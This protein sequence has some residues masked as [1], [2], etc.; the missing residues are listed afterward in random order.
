MK[1]AF[2]TFTL[3]MFL[4]NSFAV[5]AWAKPCFEE[6]KPMPTM[7]HEMGDIP[8][9]EK[10]DVPKKSGQHCEGACLCLHTSM[11][12]MN[13]PG[14]SVISDIEMREAKPAINNNEDAASVKTAPPRRPPKLYS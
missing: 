5:A 12:Q 7:S 8:C 11:T 14:D 10:Q 3:I 13:I 2:L 9:H 1:A 4:A 6:E